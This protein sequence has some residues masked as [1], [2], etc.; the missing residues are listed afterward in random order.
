VIQERL[1]GKQNVLRAQ[2]SGDGGRMV[3]VTGVK[4]LRHVNRTEE[5]ARKKMKYGKEVAERG[6]R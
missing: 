6:R 4:E 2:C 3:R 5:K 1:D